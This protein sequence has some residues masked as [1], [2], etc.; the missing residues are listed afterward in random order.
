MNALSDEVKS[1]DAQ[2]SD[3]AWYE[4]TPAEQLAEVTRRRGEAAG[5]LEELEAQWLEISE[6][7]QACV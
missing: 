4:K 2:L 5:E 6:E 1:L 7:I 3:T